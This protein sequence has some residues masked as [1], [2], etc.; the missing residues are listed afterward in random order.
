MMKY[1]CG[2]GED[3]NFIVAETGFDP[4][5]QGKAEAVFCLGNGRMGVRSAT[6]ESYRDQTR[7]MFV[8]GTFNRS[9]PGDF[10]E[11]PNCADLIEAEI[12]L[13]GEIFD[14][15]KGTVRRYL[16]Q[17][18]LRT[19]ELTRE[20][21]FTTAA[22]AEFEL[23]FRRFVSLDNL[24][25]IG[26]EIRIVPKDDA[27]V[28]ILSG[29]NG[30]MTNSGAQHFEER[31]QRIFDRDI[32]QSAYRTN[33]SGIDFLYTCNSRT[34]VDGKP[35]SDFFYSGGR[36]HNKHGIQ[37][38]VKRGGE[39]VWTKFSTV[40]TSRDREFRDGGFD[41]QEAGREAVEEMRSLRRSEFQSLLDASAERWA[42]RWA[43]MDVRIEGDDFSQLAIRFAEYHLNIM[44]PV[45]DDRCSI[46]AKG[47]SGEGYFGHAFWD[48]EIFIFPFFLYTFPE[49]AATLLRYR[50]NTLPGARRK[51]QRNGFAGAMYPWESAESGEEETP[52]YAGVNPHTGLP[53]R[54]W[55]GDIELHITS[56]VAFCIWE[57][58][59]ISGDTEFLERFGCEIICS[60]A[61]FWSS[62]LEWKPERNRY[63]ITDVIGP[64]EYKEHVDNNAF[65]NYFAHWTISRAVEYVRKYSGETAPFWR[66]LDKRFDFSG[67]C[68]KWEEQLPLIY[69]PQPRQ[70]GVIPQDDTYL[71]LRQIDLTPYKNQERVGLIYS[72]YSPEEISKI[73]VS[74]QADLL[75]LFYLLEDQFSREVKIANW[76]YY[77]PR[78]VHDSSLSLSTHCILAC[79]TGRYD[80]AWKLF[81]QAAGIDLGPDMHSSDYGIHAASLGG[82]W[83]CVVC[84]FG[85]VRMLNGALKINPSLPEKWK[86]LE[87]FINWHGDRLQVLVERNRTTVKKLTGCNPV[88]ELEVC[89]RNVQL[90]DEVT[91]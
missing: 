58:C 85:G 55:T 42:E 19:G 32:L 5:C 68:R 25:L 15:S 37:A 74:K 65:T 49:F 82:V 2:R 90:I 66:E 10:N 35:V 24:R 44:A 30:R 46:G 78:T 60:A 34:T 71:E 11:L 41:F 83:Q 67:K 88:L 76:N 48:N 54:I 62:R 45:H 28:S 12:R 9:A 64:D 31:A 43:A 1:D 3:R 61:E 80:L 63:E 17:L 29:I 69:L 36:R 73:Q 91:L 59:R 23:Q 50:Y 39:L 26:Q 70:D 18:N 72:H 6:E 86:S 56:D 81:R 20:I 7:G 89:G 75:V 21:G 79:D 47:L 77:E 52:Q 13:N 87:F 57:Y 22:G 38:E 8:V 4:S 16:R 51:A 27:T 53:Y 14:L 33:H 40:V 84:G